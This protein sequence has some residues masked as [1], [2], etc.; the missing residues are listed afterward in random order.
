[1]TPLEINLLVSVGVIIFFLIQGLM[2]FRRNQTEQS[3]FLMNRQL[4]TEEFSYSF[5]AA[6]TS[7]ATV[8]FFFTVLGLNFGLYIFYAPLTYFIGVLIFNKILLPKLFQQGYFD[9][10]R[11]VS[12]TNISAVGTTLGNYLMFRLNSKLIKYTVII[13][14]LIGMFSILLIE[15]Y[16]GVNIFSVYFKPE[17][18]SIALVGLTLVVFLYTGFGGFEAVV[19]TDKLQYRL[20]LGATLIFLGWLIFELFEKS[21]SLN[22]ND[23]FG[24]Q[25]PLSQGIA[26]PYPLLF[27]ILAVNIL[28]IPAMLRT[29]QM[30][31][32]SGNL[33]TVKQGNLSGAKMTF[34]LTAAFVLI[35]ILFFKYVFPIAPNEGE[36][37]LLMMFQK[38]QSFPDTVGPFVIFP[39]FFAACLAALISTA[40]SA[41]MPIMQSL[42]QDFGTTKPNRAFPLRKLV[43]VCV[44]LFALTLGLYFIVFKVLQF[45]LI[46]WLYTIFS[47]LIICSPLI[48]FT[49]LAPQNILEKPA[50]KY[51]LFFVLV[52]GFAIAIGLSLYGNSSKNQ[53]I[54]ML[55]SPISC[56]FIALFYSLYYLIQKNK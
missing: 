12:S 16:V 41:L 9:N 18:S 4:S 20:I 15:L 39:I 56:G 37:S 48:F 53:T 35:G 49:V 44:I 38:L 1:M 24:I 17:Y 27:N 26:L 23:F 21:I 14:T 10:S 47:F 2:S 6:S 8:L 19:R 28:L 52:I 42:V 43:A 13:L 25:L 40:D 50:T 5:A 33:E 54:V 11:T 34:L 51:F 7:L 36:P 29:W 31:S 22:S 32:A 55:N 46:S 30:A 3:Y 45:D